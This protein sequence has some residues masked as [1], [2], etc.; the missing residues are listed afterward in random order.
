M[1]FPG[2]AWK[3]DK[4]QVGAQHSGKNFGSIPGFT[5]RMLRPS[6]DTLQNV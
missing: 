4:D 2:F 1:P 3:R 5:C 6:G